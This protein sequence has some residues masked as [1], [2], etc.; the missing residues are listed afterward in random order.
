MTLP[1]VSSLG[2]GVGVAAAV[3][4]AL[5]LSATL[6]HRLW[7]FCKKPAY[8]EESYLGKAPATTSLRYS[9]QGSITSVQH[10]GGEHGARESSIQSEDVSQNQLVTVLAGCLYLLCTT[11][12]PQHDKRA[13]YLTLNRKLRYMPLCA[14][15]GPFNLGTTHHVC[16]MLSRVFRD[17]SADLPVVWVCSDEPAD[18]TNAAFLL[19]AYLCLVRGATPSEAMQP[20]RSL[21]PS[22][23]LPFR[24][25]TWVK[26]SYD[27]TLCDCWAGLLRAVK[28]GLYSPSSFDKN[29]Y[30]YY[31]APSNGTCLL[32]TTSRPPRPYPDCY[33]LPALRG[34]AMRTY[35]FDSGSGYMCDGRRSARSLAREV[36]SLQGPG[37]REMSSSGRQLC[38]CPS[39]LRGCLPG[40]GSDG[41]S[42]AQLR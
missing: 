13:I 4:C 18:V 12:V 28:T 36:Y 19:G 14:D 27:L 11:K 39:A 17:K 15:F 30:F 34:L 29:E 41:C 6:L 23:I 32:E 35:V 37:V 33:V 20:F 42:A 5:F 16:A 38:L 2:A 9:L 26:S 21:N 40:E 31:D 25:A 3:C 1:T 7:E 24:D 8:R 22:Y 10:D